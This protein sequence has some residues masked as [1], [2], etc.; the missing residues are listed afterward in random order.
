MR[1]FLFRIFEIL[2]IVLFT[3]AAWGACH[4]ITPN[5]SGNNSGSDWNN[6]CNGLSGSC[7]PSSGMLRGDSY[8]IAKGTY[9]SVTWSKGDS[10][11]SNIS[12]KSPTAGDHCTDTGFVQGTHVGQ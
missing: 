12:V 9:S 7:S 4:V 8:Y 5:G 3:S 6:S 2:N 11:S 10:G 1:R